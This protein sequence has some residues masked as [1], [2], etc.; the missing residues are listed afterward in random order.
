MPGDEEM[1][2]ADI[3]F[4]YSLLDA[5]ARLQSMTVAEISDVMGNSDWWTDLKNWVDRQWGR[6]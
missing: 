1:R 6:R 4:K 3:R 5:L 2:K